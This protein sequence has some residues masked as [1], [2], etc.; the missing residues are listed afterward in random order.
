MIR[1]LIVNKAH[2]HDDISIL[3]LMLTGFLS[4]IFKNCIDCV[5][6]QNTRKM[7]HII[8][9]YEK[10]D[11]HSLNNYHPVS[12]LPICKKISQRI[13]VKCFSIPWK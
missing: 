8:P 1:N 10:N 9:I 6:F 12:L 4:I 2:D 11:K 3:V 7:S 5:L 13:I